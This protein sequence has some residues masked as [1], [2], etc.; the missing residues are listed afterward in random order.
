MANRDIYITEEDYEQLNQLLAGARLRRTRDLAHVD[1]LDAELD[2]AHIVP[3]DE[4]PAD[5]VTMN[6]QIALRDLDTGDEMVLTLVFPHQANVDQQRGARRT[7][8]RRRY[9]K[10]CWRSACRCLRR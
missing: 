7:A 8:H 5:V 10:T 3:A 2:R 6:S 1:Q 9:G 4:I